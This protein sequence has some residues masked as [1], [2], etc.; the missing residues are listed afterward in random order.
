MAPAPWLELDG[1]L[2]AVNAAAPMNALKGDEEEMRRMRG[3]ARDVS[4]GLASEA[5]GGKGCCGTEDQLA[6]G[7]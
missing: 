7:I 2:L 3:Y 1:S 6:G 4:G 5:E